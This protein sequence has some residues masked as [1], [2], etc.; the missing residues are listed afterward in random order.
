MGAIVEAAVYSAIWKVILAFVILPVG[1]L[2]LGYLIYIVVG[3]VKEFR[4]K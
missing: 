3:I 2:F 4:R 1:V